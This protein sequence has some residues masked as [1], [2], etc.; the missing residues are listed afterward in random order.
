MFLTKA[1]LDGLNS[2][3]LDSNFSECFHSAS[4]EHIWATI[5]QTIYNAMHQFT[6]KV[7]LKSYECPES[8]LSLVPSEE[9][10]LYD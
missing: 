5:K 3:L 1:D 7:K 10:L 9:G 2:Y 8:Q 6:P 4:V